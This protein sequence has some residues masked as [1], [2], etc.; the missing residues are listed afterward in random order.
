MYSSRVYV[1][2]RCIST[3]ARK[4]HMEP[5]ALDGARS[6][7]FLCSCSPTCPFRVYRGKRKHSS[8]KPQTFPSG[9]NSNHQ[10]A[11]NTHVYDRFP[12]IR[13]RPINK[14]D[15][16][17]WGEGNV[18]AARPTKHIKFKTNKLTKAAA[19]SQDQSQKPQQEKDKSRLPKRVSCGVVLM[20]ST[21]LQWKCWNTILQIGA[22][23]VEG[24]LR[25]GATPGVAR[26]GFFRP[27]VA[28]I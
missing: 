24:W 26:V 17:F 11:T 19:A 15:G 20:A 21:K 1:E 2:N 13:M 28:F 9:V 27:R 12:L 18:R 6:F 22:P 7:F 4:G 3:P 23:F 5:R 25:R 10:R 8:P 14:S 16:L